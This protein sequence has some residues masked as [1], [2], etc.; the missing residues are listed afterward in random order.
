MQGGWLSNTYDFLDDLEALLSDF[1]LI[2]SCLQ[3]NHVCTTVKLLLSIYE[4]HIINTA[5]NLCA[6]AA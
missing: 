1:I 2:P 5:I 4:L 6:S 3:D